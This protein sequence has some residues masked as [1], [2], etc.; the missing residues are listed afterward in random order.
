M[1]PRRD[2]S[3]LISIV[4]M[5]SV[6]T[7]TRCRLLGAIVIII[8]FYSVMW[9]KAKEA[10]VDMDDGVGSLESSAHLEPLL[11]NSVEE[12]RSNLQ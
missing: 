2:S 5:T 3:F 8:G 9:G 6:G 4:R 7:I 1:L 12:H 11:Q 10:K